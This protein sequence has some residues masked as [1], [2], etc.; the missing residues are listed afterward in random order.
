MYEYV[1]YLQIVAPDVQQDQLAADQRLLQQLL[2]LHRERCGKKVTVSKLNTTWP[3]VSWQW[4][5]LALSSLLITLASTAGL[6]VER[7]F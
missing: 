2:N 1:V 4:E 6:T 3:L 7:Q 5:R